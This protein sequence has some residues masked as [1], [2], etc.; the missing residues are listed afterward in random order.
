MKIVDGAIKQKAKLIVSHHPIFKANPDHKLLSFYASLIKKIKANK[1]TVLSLHTCFDNA[2][3]GMN[4]VVGTRLG[5]KNLKWFDKAKFVTGLC[6]T[7]TVKQIASD[8]KKLFNVSLLTT[9]AQ[10]NDKFNKLAICAG[11]GLSVFASK[12]D[13]L[14]KQK[15]LLVTGDIKHH[16]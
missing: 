12:F 11:A 3:Q 10:P 6:K 2:D 15:I 9:N 16:G 5:L 8:F 13:Q 7:K 1:V 14:T 4:F